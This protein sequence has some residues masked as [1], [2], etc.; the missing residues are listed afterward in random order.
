V[1]VR[2]DVAAAPVPQAGQLFA[3]AEISATH[4]L[5]Y[6]GSGH[7]QSIVRGVPSCVG[8]AWRVKTMAIRMFFLC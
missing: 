3:C 1:V 5:P 4:A 2:V 6:H 8:A 7:K